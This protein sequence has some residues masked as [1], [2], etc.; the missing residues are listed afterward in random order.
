MAE[1][2]HTDCYGMPW[3]S[4]GFLAVPNDNEFSATLSDSELCLRSA[5]IFSNLPDEHLA[6]FQNEARLRSYKKGKILY[7][8]EDDAEYFYIISSGWIKLFHTMPEGDEVIIDMLTKGDLVGESALFENGFHTSS[9][10]VVEDVRLLSIPMHTLRDQVSRN[11][12]LAYS[13]LSTLSR[14]HRRHCGEMA[15][16]AKQSAPQRVGYFL[17][18][19]CPKNKRQSIKFALPY[20]KTLIASA[21]GMKNE[22]FSR[23]LNFLR[24]KI[25]LR[26]KG[27]S[28]EIDSIEQLAGF[29]YGTPYVECLSF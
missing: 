22:T 12:S 13:M 20:D 27:A 5:S 29:V 4:M 3:G 21:L 8:E 1:S 10:Q 18:K 19:L 2:I 15:L 7:L 23:A 28:V 11:A 9:A 24:H 16:H 6:I 26:I 17:L 25:G 14:R